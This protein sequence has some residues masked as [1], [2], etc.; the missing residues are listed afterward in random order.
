MNRKID[1]V[2]GKNEVV[3]GRTRWGKI[4]FMMMRYVVDVG[5]GGAED[6]HGSKCCEDGCEKK[7]DLGG[8]NFAVKF[9]YREPKGGTIVEYYRADGRFK[10]MD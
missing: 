2:G 9:G 8:Q 1:A 4:S 6:T 7:H 10:L 5:N 3:L